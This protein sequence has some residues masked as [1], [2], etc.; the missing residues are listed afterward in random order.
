MSYLLALLLMRMRLIKVNLVSD[1]AWKVYC[2]WYYVIIRFRSQIL[3]LD[4]PISL[5]PTKFDEYQYLSWGLWAMSSPGNPRL[6]LYH[7]KDPA[8]AGYTL[9]QCQTAI[10]A[11]LFGFAKSVDEGARRLFRSNVIQI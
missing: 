11:S 1:S 10:R 4:P 2:G 7:N 5:V 8:V 6:S 3:D 9:R